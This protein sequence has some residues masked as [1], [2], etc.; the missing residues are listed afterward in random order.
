M[1]QRP[2]YKWNEVRI[3]YVSLC[4]KSTVSNI[5][6]SVSRVKFLIEF[7]V[8]PVLIICS[9]LSTSSYIVG[10]T[11]TN[12]AL[13]RRFIPSYF[14]V[15]LAAKNKIKIKMIEI[16]NES[17]WIFFFF[18]NTHLLTISIPYKH[19]SWWTLQWKH[20]NTIQNK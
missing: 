18:Y 9:S 11:K 12:P 20:R 14:G 7:L 8:W 10:S 17:P 5:L 4:H 16:N 6:L 13:G 2:T 1:L 3:I 19:R 15:Q